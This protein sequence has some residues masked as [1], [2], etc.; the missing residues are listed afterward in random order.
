MESLEFDIRPL[1][2]QRLG[3]LLNFFE[4]RAFADHPKWASC[5]CHFPHADHDNIVWAERT[6]EQNRAATCQRVADGT[7]MGWLAYADTGDGHGS[8]AVGWCNAGPR[9]FIEGMLDEPEPLAAQIGAIACFVVAPEFRGRGVARALLNAAC[10]GL[11]EQGFEWAEAYPRRDVT[12][13]GANHF[14]PL[15]M[16]L[17][18]GFGVHGAEGDDGFVMRT[19]LR[20]AGAA[21]P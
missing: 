15:A 10:G 5:Y 7:M 17:A 19:R 11:R 16:Y 1:T 21:T 13:A 9:R 18:A 12:D 14:G 20:A 6:G 2:P 4:Q 3:D 8:Q